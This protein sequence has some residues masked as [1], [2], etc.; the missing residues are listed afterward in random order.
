MSLV[1]E[2]PGCLTDG[3]TPAEALTNLNEAM[4][5]WFESHLLYGDPIPVPAAAISAYT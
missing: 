4:A 5:A 3:E 2:L 1:P